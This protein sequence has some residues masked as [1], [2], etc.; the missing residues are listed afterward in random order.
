MKKPVIKSGLGALRKTAASVKQDDRLMKDVH[1]MVDECL[2]NPTNALQNFNT[3]MDNRRRA[4]KMG[5]AEGFVRVDVDGE[6]VLLSGE[7]AQQFIDEAEEGP[8]QEQRIAAKMKRV[9]TCM[10]EELLAEAHFVRMLV[11][12]TL[13]AYVTGLGDDDSDEAKALR[14]LVTSVQIRL[15]RR[16]TVL[17]QDGDTLKAT[18]KAISEHRKASGMEEFERAIQQLQQARAQGDVATLQRLTGVIQTSRAAYE[19]ATHAIDPSTHTCKIARRDTQVHISVFLRY[20]EALVHRKK[21][22]LVSSVSGLR[23]SVESSGGSPSIELQEKEKELE[24]IQQQENFVSAQARESEAVAAAVTKSQGLSPT[25]PQADVQEIMDKA[26]VKAK[27]PT[28]AAPEPEPETKGKSS[29]MHG[30]R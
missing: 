14:S 15:Q 7:E 5:P 23:E 21:E 2:K 18:E 11:E 8:E 25:T 22:A 20:L 19:R 27:K 29:G 6:V 16:V 1:K 26:G 13:E 28:S 4:N 24:N 9:L 30:R 3:F 12:A 17:D 10:P